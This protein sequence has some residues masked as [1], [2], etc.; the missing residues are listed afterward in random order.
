MHGQNYDFTGLT[1]D[2][3]VSCI[4]GQQWSCV[5]S[6]LSDSIHCY[7]T[8]S[9]EF[10]KR[11]CAGRRA[12]AAES[13]HFCHLSCLQ[14][15]SRCAPVESNLIPKM[16]AMCVLQCRQSLWRRVMHFFMTPGG[17]CLFGMSSLIPLSQAATPHR[18]KSTV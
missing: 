4:L 14:T 8:F 2:R 1:L 10:E 18:S 7:D 5:F 3:D 12:S 9:F 6:T 15:A 11:P 13:K 17:R 16:P